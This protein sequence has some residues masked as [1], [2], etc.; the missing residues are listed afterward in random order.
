[1]FL[2]ASQ[3]DVSFTH[4]PRG[5]D[6]CSG[7]LARTPA[8]F[9]HHGS[10]IITMEGC[11]LYVSNCP[12]LFIRRDHCGLEARDLGSSPWTNHPPTRASASLLEREGSCA[13]AVG[14][15]SSHLGELGKNTTAKLHAL[16]KVG[17]SGWGLCIETGTLS[18]LRLAAQAF[19]GALTVTKGLP[20]LGTLAGP[21]LD[22]WT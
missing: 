20:N 11:L 6:H 4:L 16:Y 21:A 22:L 3:G 8:P 14:P 18:E 9:P 12:R 13:E 1:M 2:S 19:S 17:G 5:Q 15:W 7:G 10:H